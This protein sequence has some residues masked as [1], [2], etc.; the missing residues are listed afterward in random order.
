MVFANT[1]AV[2]PVETYLAFGILQSR[3]HEIWARFFGSS[4]KDDFRYTPS[5]CF[6]TFPFPDNWDSNPA[7]EAIGKK[8]Y[9]FRAELMVRN[10][11]G[12]TNIYNRFH[13]PDEHDDAMLQLRELHAQMDRAILDAYGWSDIPTTYKFLLDYEEEEKEVDTSRRKKPWRYRWPEEVHDEVL[14]RLLVLNQ[15][16]AEAERRLGKATAKPKGKSHKKTSSLEDLPL[17]TLEEAKS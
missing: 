17:L 2:F 15:Q 10:S 16:R 6:E 1:L 3:I 14:A 13:D 11:Q 9:E 4:M 5:D 7:L 12:L 8:Y